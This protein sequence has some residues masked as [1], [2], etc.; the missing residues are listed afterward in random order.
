MRR[1]AGSTWYSCTN[2]GVAVSCA[3]TSPQATV[4]AANELT[5]VAAQ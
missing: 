3:T 1:S 5:V 4:A 2:T